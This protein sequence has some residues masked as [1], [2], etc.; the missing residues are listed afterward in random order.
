ML[1]EAI[2]ATDGHLDPPNDE[3]ENT[4]KGDKTKNL[5]DPK[6]KA[7]SIKSNSVGPKCYNLLVYL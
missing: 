7:N 6:V 3:E 5:F 1:V 2:L 4:D